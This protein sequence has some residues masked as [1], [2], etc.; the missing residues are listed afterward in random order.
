DSVSVATKKEAKKILDT[1]INKII[2]VYEKFDELITENADYEYEAT[3]GM[4]FASN[5][6]LES[7][8]PY[9]TNL[10][11]SILIDKKH[12]KEVEEKLLS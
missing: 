1:D 2:K 6:T 12:S 7:L 9:N 4:F 8:T 11:F 3:G 5:K 10:D